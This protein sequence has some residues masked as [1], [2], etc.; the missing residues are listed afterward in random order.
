MINGGW[1]KKIRVLLVDDSAVI[2]KVLGDLISSDPEL[3]IVGTAANGKLALQQL[4]LL[5][6]DIVTLDIEMPEMDGLQ[7]VQE[8]RKTGSN[9]PIIMCS[10]LTATGAT[11]TLDALAFGASDYVT[12]PSSHGA[13]TREV[14]GEELIRKIKGLAGPGAREAHP[15]RPSEV[16]SR[17]QVARPSKTTTIIELSDAPATTAPS[18]PNVVAIGVSTGGPNAL[19]EVLPLLPANLS[20]PVLI[21]QH[22]PPLFTKLLAERLNAT[23]KLPV[24]EATD[25]QEVKAGYIYL[26]PGGLHMEVKRL[27]GRT[28]IQLHEGPPE[29]SC[30]PAVDVLFRSVASV[31]G[32]SALAVMLTGMGQ[33]GLI[34]CQNIKAVGGSIIAQDR[35]SSA[36]WGMP[37][38]VVEAGLATSVVPLR[39]IAASITSAVSQRVIATAPTEQRV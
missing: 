19:Q 23:S 38:A 16:G 26:A 9:V 25:R 8:I 30:R 36:V 20:V 18:Q 27:L 15:P 17:P 32:P 21:V 39:S 10:S 3:E 11:H 35:E 28:L 22:M 33:D 1:M 13:N 6:P 2:R 37:G 7:T 4:A 12:K 31:Y 24:V 29:N 5:N 34:G 14:I